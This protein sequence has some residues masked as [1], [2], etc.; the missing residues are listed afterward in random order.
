VDGLH[1][2]APVRY[3]GV[4]IGTVTKIMLSYDQPADDQHIPVFIELDLEKVRSGG[5]WP[6]F[7]PEG[8]IPAIERGL[9][10]QLQTESLLTGLL[11]VQLDFQP[12]TPAH[13]VGLTHPVPEIP[14]LPTALEQVQT[15][16]RRLLAKI[17][18][19]DIPGIVQSI[20][21]TVAAL[22]RLAKSAEIERTLV[23]LR[24]T[25]E[26]VRTL[27]EELQTEISPAV[28]TF[29]A[30]AERTRGTL[31]ELELTLE[32]A[33]AVIAPDS[34]LAYQIGKTLEEISQ[35]AR[36]VRA[37]ADSLDRDP[38]VLLRGR[39]QTRDP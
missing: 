26:S 28:A 29:T 17:E 18:H 23:A 33:R 5:G 20:R 31:G 11:F 12:D 24:A 13:F 39:A 34:P 21:D 30:A 4:D 9:R 7:S 22:D 6:D 15:V 36:G 8:M 16:V 14:T 19:I 10:A 2:G 38:A 3:K 27:S 32:S 25:L 1:V 37:L 35:A